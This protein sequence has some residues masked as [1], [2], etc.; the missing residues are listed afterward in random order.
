MHLFSYLLQA[1]SLWG[2]CNE[3]TRIVA[4]VYFDM[5]FVLNRDR[6]LF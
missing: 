2:E 5:L 4:H 1:N 6:I 3:I